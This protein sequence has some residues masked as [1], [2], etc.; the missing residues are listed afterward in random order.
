M[1]INGCGQKTNILPVKIQ[2]PVAV[3]EHL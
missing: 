2:S 3:S 1:A